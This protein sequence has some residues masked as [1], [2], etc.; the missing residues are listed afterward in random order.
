[1]LYHIFPFFQE[2]YLSRTNV[3]S[4]TGVLKGR[5]FGALVGQKQAANLVLCLCNAVLSS[6]EMH[7]ARFGGLINIL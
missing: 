6:V 5:W 2:V 7:L 4:S 1:M 3:T